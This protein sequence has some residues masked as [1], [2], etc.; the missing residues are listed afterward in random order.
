MQFRRE[1]NQNQVQ[2][3]IVPN[4]MTQ[5]NSPAS[6]S[7]TGQQPSGS[8]TPSPNGQSQQN[9]QQP[10][11]LQPGQVA[12]MDNQF[13]PKNLTPAAGD[14]S[15]GQS[16]STVAGPQS[17]PSP[18]QQSSQYA[19]MEQRLKDFQAMHPDSPDDAD[20]TFLNQLQSQRNMLNP[21]GGQNPPTD[22]PQA[23]SA[24]GGAALPPVQI[25]SL[26]K[27]VASKGLADLLTKA[28]DATKA[29]KY[30]QAIGIY[31][32]AIEVAPNNGLILIGRAH[33]EMGG[34]YYRQADSDI[35]S[36]FHREPSLLMAQYDLQSQVGDDRLTAIIAELKQIAT[37]SPDSSTPVFLLAY[38]AYNTHHEDKAGQWLNVAHQRDPQD[39]VIPEIN[40]HWSLTSSP[41]TKP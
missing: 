17:V 35:R 1:M 14:F 13:Q 23:N 38:I 31:N 26:A 41:T 18:S 34:S 40:K 20:Q 37:N 16:L 33:A 22:L 28:E 24:A 21:Q 39:E 12:P 11:T 3:Q 30:D 29:G 27:G 4:D 5:P 25:G 2:N 15:T 9:S 6:S 36:A 7:N 8:M 32:S 10:N 19:Q